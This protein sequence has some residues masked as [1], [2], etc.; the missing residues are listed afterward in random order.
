MK[1]IFLLITMVSVLHFAC[2]EV[3]DIKSVIESQGP[4]VLNADLQKRVAQD[5][6]FALDLLKKTINSADKNNV[7]ISPLSVSIALGM[8]WNGADGETRTEMESALKMSGMS[9]ENI[10]D[11]YK[12]M[13][14]SLPTVD[15]STTV[16][17][18]NSIWYKSEFQ[19][20]QPFLVM[21]KIYFNAEVRSLD[22]SATWAVDTINGWC[23]QKTNNLIKN[24]LTTIPDYARMYLI[25][26]IYF[27][28]LWTNPF[29]TKSTYPTNFS[30]ELGQTT[31]IN[32]M[33]KID[34]FSYFSDS[35]AQYLDLPYGNK[36]FSMTV[37][38]PVNGKTTS[39]VLNYLT[40][41]RL[42]NALEN[43]KLQQVL[44]NL[45]R[46]KAECRFE[47]NDPLKAMGM[48]KAFE[49]TADFSKISDESLCISSVIHK[50]YVEVTEEGTKAA[51]VTVIEFITTSMPDYQ[52]FV[53]NKP[54]LFLI[55]EKGTGVILFAGKMGAVEK[56]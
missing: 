37:I 7:F 41:D 11:Y 31:Q 39:D 46:F 43:L 33:S 56:Y 15:S 16:K 28:G 47:L 48:K 22:F 38:L 24:V 3:D 29:D 18:A 53:V 9:I 52:T 21:N 54:F 40:N 34:T 23:A 13:L 8:A 1:K 19:I 14:L 55:R 25:N 17:I 30:N 44:V 36:D 12:I 45:P 35:Y 5:N 20:K 42:S 10:N 4:I 50:T 51:A 27:K 32:M 6:E 2:T 26:A 49:N